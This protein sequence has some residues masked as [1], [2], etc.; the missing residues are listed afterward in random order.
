MV[1]LRSSSR[2]AASAPT[3]TAAKAQSSLTPAMAVS[4]QRFSA[5]EIAALVAQGDALMGKREIPS[6]RLFFRQAADAG[7]GRAALRLGVTFDPAF[8]HYAKLP[9]ALGNQAEALA[10]YRRAR[11][12][13]SQH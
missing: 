7:D 12:L 8:L 3:A 4:G 2:I 1:L 10:W 11:D 6:A 5:A 13:N 9:G